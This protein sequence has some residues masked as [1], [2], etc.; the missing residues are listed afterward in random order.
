M[1]QLFRSQASRKI[2]GVC[3]GIGEMLDADPVVVRLITV[4]LALVTGILPFVI[5]YII[6]WAIV[7]EKTGSAQSG[8][9]YRN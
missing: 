9:F 5:G 2:A 1:K 8:P 3:G 4:L 6:A 7:P